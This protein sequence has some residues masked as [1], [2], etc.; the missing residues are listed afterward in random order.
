MPPGP[1]F[2]V[3]VSRDGEFYLLQITDLGW[4]QAETE[5]EIETMARDFIAET[6]NQPSDSFK[7]NIISV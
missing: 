7:I 3:R 6:T 5:G 2:D 4:T 1:T